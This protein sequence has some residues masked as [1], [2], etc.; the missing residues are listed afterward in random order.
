MNVMRKVAY[1]TIVQIAG[2]FINIFLALVLLRHL[3]EYLEVKGYGDYTT[4][5]SFVGVFSIV[6]DFGLNLIVV[7]DLSKRKKN[8]EEYLGN[9]IGL[10]TVAALATMVLAPVGALFF[11]YSKD[12]QI[13][14]AL[15]A[16]GAY[17]L[18]IN[19][20]FVGV[21]QSKLQLDK[22]VLSDVIGKITYFGLTLLFIKMNYGFLSVAAAILFGN[23]VNLTISLLLVKKQVKMSIR[24]D[25]TEWKRIFYEMMPMGIVLVLGMIYI[26]SDIILLS[27]LKGSRDVGIYGVAYK[28][29][30]ILIVMSAF[31]MGA[32][33][34][35][36]TK[37]YQED[38]ERFRVLLQRST[39]VLLVVA[40]PVGVLF[41]ILAKHFIY[42]VAPEEFGGAIAA[43]Q[44]LIWGIVIS[45]ITSVANYTIIAI[46]KQK[47]LIWV[48]V[49]LCVLNIGLNLIFIP[50]HSFYA[51][52]IITTLTELF[53]L[54]LNWWLAY[55]YTSFRPSFRMMG[56]LFVIGLAMSAA[57]YILR[58]NFVLALL[59]G[60]IIYAALV[61]KWGV[62]DKTMIRNLL[63]R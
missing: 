32:V 39:D 56:K 7:R 16:L 58:E 37:A 4:A 1:N 9:V 44:L 52:S 15:I 29:Y 60:L 51:A 50:R 55:K 59:S 54:I 10:R 8:I 11:P 57:V 26:R 47:A 42:L 19:Q 21:F 38:K 24:F 28:F 36:I 5:I 22:S 35:L 53:A 43:L 27:V 41:F 17:F 2:R 34:P 45:Y 46:N 13:A 40:M 33:F 49:F 62:V 3:T 14:I 25:F 63:G 48:Y 31:F 18:S 23:F 12:L 61:I 6:A 20:I 30:D